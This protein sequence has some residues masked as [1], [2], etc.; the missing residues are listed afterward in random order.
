MRKSFSKFALAASVA[1]A[2]AFTLSCSS[3][4]DSGGGDS[5]NSS[6]GNSSS[7]GGGI[8]S[9]SGGSNVVY[10]PS[11][12]HEGKTYKSVKIGTQTW[13]TE[14]LNYNVSGSKCNNNLESN[15]AIYGRLYDW[16]TAMDLP[17]SCRTSYC[18]SQIQPK[19]R[20]ICPQ[21]WHIPSSAEWTVL[22]S[23]VGNS[24]SS[25]GKKLRATSGW[26]EN[27]GTDDFGFAALPGGF[28]SYESS[29]G[30]A[31]SLG[32]WWSATEDEDYADFAYQWSIDYQT[33]YVIKKGYD[34]SN[35]HSV[36][37][38]QD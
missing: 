8:S 17:N 2:M 30:N 23:F 21:G 11:V 20:G 26:Y 9:P 13:M 1:L 31:G 25:A 33:D 7:S 34:K 32:Y 35:L 4:D 18:S 28:G 3:D 15:C 38:I 10:G 14:N 5:G 37:C 24:S 6:N 19:H 22:I 36:R 16:V 27:N 12:P 29:D